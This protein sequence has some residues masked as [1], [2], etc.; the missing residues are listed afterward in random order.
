MS[1]GNGQQPGADQN[2]PRRAAINPSRIRKMVAAIIGTILMFTTV[3]GL[4]L[5]LKALL[6]GMIFLFWVGFGIFLFIRKNR[7]SEEAD[8]NT[9]IPTVRWAM[10]GAIFVIL[11]AAAFKEIENRLAP[12]RPPLS[13]SIYSMI[14]LD[15][16]EKMKSPFDGSSSKWVAIQSAFQDYFIRAN[17]LSN[18][19]LVV[20]G[21]QNP[22]E[23][24]S[25]ACGV[26]TVPLIPLVFGD[27]HGNMLPT[28]D[29]S[30][31]NLRTQIEGQQPQGGGSLSRAF[32]LA[33]NQLEN[34]P[35]D[36][37]AI[38]IIVLVAGVSDTCKGEID[39]DALVNDIQLVNKEIAIHKELILLDET[40]DSAVAEI[41]RIVGQIDPS[42][43]GS[44]T[45]MQV[46]S[47]PAELRES[48]SNVLDRL[49]AYS[50]STSLADAI[51]SGN[52]KMPASPTLRVAGTATKAK[53]RTKATATPNLVTITP[54]TTCTPSFTSTVTEVPLAST[55]REEVPASTITFTPT[56]TFTP[57]IT[58][59]PTI[60]PYPTIKPTK[61]I[62]KT[63]APVPTNPPPPPTNPPPPTDEPC[64]MHCTEISKPCGDV[65]IPLDHN[66]TKPK[67]CACKP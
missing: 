49:E 9:L 57:T 13:K 60:T 30:L 41:A 28:K 44:G 45:Y 11:I 50:A 52:T 17:E 36:T 38:R 46:A 18:Y 8:Q 12:P 59:I 1:T 31:T 39:W 2:K 21:G 24:G 19:G 20:I 27:G 51:D 42:V 25:G 34:L 14:V 61:K 5:P 7:R 58:F 4:S 56:L 15:A 29:L 54:T 64:C 40:P 47:T 35:L 22:N 16:S 10:M 48:I 37:D 63:V 23:K 66:C 32:F 6:A 67:G 62:I 65:C 43:E 26:P 3:I 53:I 33:K 55:M